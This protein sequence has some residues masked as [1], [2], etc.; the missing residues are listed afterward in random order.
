M[1]QETYKGKYRVKNPAKYR[2]DYH[3]VIYRSSWELKLMNW[4]DTTPAVLEWGSEV[5]VIPYVSPVDKKV[6]RY[7]VDFYMKIQDKN[8]RVEKYLVEVKPKKFTQEPVK[9]K[10][11]TK[12]FLEEVFTYGVNQAKWKAAK[13]F[14]EDRQWKFVV[15]T[16]DE[17]NINGYSKKSV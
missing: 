14:C 13:E 12:Q 7:F 3:N 11:V 8:G 1:Y 17:L 5:A 10:R 15:L 2:G 4:C 6:H 9:P 16:E